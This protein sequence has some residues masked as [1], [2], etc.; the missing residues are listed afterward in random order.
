MR[1]GPRCQRGLP[2]SGFRGPRIRA[3]LASRGNPSSF[4]DGRSEC[5]TMV[6]RCVPNNDGGLLRTPRGR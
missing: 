6:Y 3:H 1:P 2:R 5:T 4:L